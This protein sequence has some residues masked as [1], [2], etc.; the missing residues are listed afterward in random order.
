MI[1]H[2]NI[3]DFPFGFHHFRFFALYC[4]LVFIYTDSLSAQ[5]AIGA[6]S[7]AMGQTG[8]AH[9]YDT[10][11]IF[12]NPSLMK[13]DVYTF[14]FYGMRYAGFDELTDLATSITLDAGSGVIGA[15]FH[16]YGF[17]LFSE[18]RFRLGYSNRA[19]GFHYG[20]ALNYS[21]VS[22]GGDY[23]SAGAVG[24]DAGLAAELGSRLLLA[25]RTMNLNRPTYGDTDEGLYRDLAIGL[26]YRTVNR[27]SSVIELVKDARFP[28]S[29]RSGIEVF[30]MPSFCIRA[31]I[32]LEPVTWS[33]GIGFI[34]ET[35]SVNIAVQNH[36]VLGLSPGVDFGTEI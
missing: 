6:R 9:Q 33:F 14:S 7:L 21:H 20:L 8:A 13:T 19:E 30:L 34:T 22:Q 10:W 2:Y 1:R 29:I 28:I 27:F 11:A 4:F 12:N 24:L 23:G 18:S 16:R 5:A 25:A 26:T 31:G 17:D 32:T 36:E 35:I 15:G 3:T